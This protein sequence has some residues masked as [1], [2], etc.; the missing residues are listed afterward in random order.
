MLRITAAALGALCALTGTSSSAQNYPSRP[1][2]VMIPFGPSSAG[3]TIARAVAPHISQ[4]IKQTLVMD[5]RPGAGGNIAAEITGHANPD[6]YTIMMAVSTLAIDATLYR[7][8]PYDPVKDLALV[9]LIATVP[10]V[11]VVSAALPVYDV[12]TISFPPEANGAFSTR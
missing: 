12:R 8:L 2:R 9:A 5:N 6:G 1:I 11:L 4:T 3:D 10:F 7:K